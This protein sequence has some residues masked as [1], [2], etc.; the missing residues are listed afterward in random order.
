MGYM[1]NKYFP[2]PQL[3]PDKASIER[4]YEAIRI[5]CTHQLVLIAQ[6]LDYLD[7]EDIIP[8]FVSTLAMLPNPVTVSR[9]MPRSSSRYAN[10]PLDQPSDLSLAKTRQQLQ[11]LFDPI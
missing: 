3:T 8:P 5:Y 1:V 2:S 10:S 7:D 6:A 4:D 11:S 9:A